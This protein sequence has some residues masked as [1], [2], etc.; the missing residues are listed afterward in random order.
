M[1]TMPHIKRMAGTDVPSDNIFTL[2]HQ[3][4]SNLMLNMEKREGQAYHGQMVEM[5]AW[6]REDEF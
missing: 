6:E 3:F 2:R 4:D 5:H 1:G